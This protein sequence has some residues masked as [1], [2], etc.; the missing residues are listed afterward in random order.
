[1]AATI[2][3]RPTLIPRMCSTVR[4]KPKFA[5]EASSIMLLGPGVPA[6]AKANRTKASSS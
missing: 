5:P 4:R 2:T 1:M 3:P 6:V